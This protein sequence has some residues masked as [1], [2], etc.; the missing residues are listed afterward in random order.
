MKTVLSVE[1]TGKGS[2]KNLGECPIVS[3]KDSQCSL[4]TILPMK[5]LVSG[6][7]SSGLIKLR[8]GL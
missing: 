6:S 1:F 3:N 2:R 5:L 8:A 4:Y 7:R